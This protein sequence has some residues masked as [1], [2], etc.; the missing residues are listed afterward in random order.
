MALSDTAVDSV[1]VCVHP[2]PFLLL[3][4]SKTPE[5]KINNTV[6]AARKVKGQHSLLQPAVTTMPICALQQHQRR[7]QWVLLKTKNKRCQQS[8]CPL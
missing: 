2:F 5:A 8:L 4:E 1:C 6:S 3:L 7:R